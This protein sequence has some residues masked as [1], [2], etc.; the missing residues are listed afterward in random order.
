LGVSGGSRRKVRTH[1][2]KRDYDINK[3]VKELKDI[4]K[5]YSLKNRNS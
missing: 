5:R 3:I 2:V 4:L 1:M